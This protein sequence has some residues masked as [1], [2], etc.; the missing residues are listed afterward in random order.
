MVGKTAKG[1][2]MK[3]KLVFLAMLVCV[4]A[5]GF[6]VTA[7]ETVGSKEEVSVNW[8]MTAAPEAPSEALRVKLSNISKEA[9][10]IYKYA[11]SANAEGNT[12]YTFTAEEKPGETYYAYKNTSEDGKSWTWE[13]YKA[14]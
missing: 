2:F 10:T 11:D 13:V 8:Q 5:L 3:K 14:R 12:W 4:L 9:S 7:C 1:V 6:M